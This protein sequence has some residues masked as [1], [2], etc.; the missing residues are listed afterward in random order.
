MLRP[1]K[2]ELAANELEG[3]RYN[4]DLFAMIGVYSFFYIFNYKFFCVPNV[5]L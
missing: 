4:S 5:Y 1:S 3:A 2:D